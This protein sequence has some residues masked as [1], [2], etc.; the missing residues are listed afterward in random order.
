M[1][2]C[3]ARR[4]CATV[5]DPARPK[6]AYVREDQ[7]LPHLA[8]LAILL[9]GPAGTP[10]RGS[11]SRAKLTGPADTAALI[12]QLRADGTVL[13]YDPDGRTLRAAVTARPRSPS[14]CT[15]LALTH[16]RT[17]KGGPP[18]ECRSVRSSLYRAC[19]THPHFLRMVP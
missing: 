15:L 7:I 10:S 12:G 2:G 1:P 5:P 8:A 11:R 18:R 4:R 13:T 6:N 14:A 19:F 16:A 3:R 9:A 17:G